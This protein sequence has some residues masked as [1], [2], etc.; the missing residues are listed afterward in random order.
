VTFSLEIVEGAGTGTAAPLLGTLVIGRGPDVDMVV[1][2]GR[3]SPRHARVTASTGGGVIVEDLGSCNG[4]FVNGQ[5]VGGPTWLAPGDELL[6]GATVLT[7]SGSDPPDPERPRADQ[8]ADCT[9]RQPGEWRPSAELARPGAEHVGP[10]ELR[11]L[12]DANVKRSAHMA[13][14]ALLAVV[15]LVVAVYLMGH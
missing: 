10:H 5:G 14:P 11:R 3:I 15:C 6:V 1:A 12:F 9:Y 8:C 4:T 13:P 7:L 2:D